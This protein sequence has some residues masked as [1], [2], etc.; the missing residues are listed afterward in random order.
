[1]MRIS[2]TAVIGITAVAVSLGGLVVASPASATTV[3]GCPSGAVCIYPQNAG[4]NGGHPSLIFYSYGYHNLTNQ[5]GTHRFYNHQ[6]GGASAYGCSG[7]GG[8]GQMLFGG[9][10]GGWSD[11]NFTPANSVVLNQS[12]AI[13]NN[14]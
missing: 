12:G 11:Q 6:T 14:C 1:M 2:R 5:F 9:D 4:W 7:F 13:P 8:T 3:Q 10:A